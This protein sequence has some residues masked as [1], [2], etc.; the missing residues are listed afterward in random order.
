MYSVTLHD[1]SSLLTTFLPRFRFLLFRCLFYW[2]YTFYFENC[3]IIWCLWM[4]HAPGAFLDT[5]LS[6]LLG[7]FLI[8]DC[9]DDVL[10]DFMTYLFSIRVTMCLHW[11]P[12]R[13][14]KWDCLLTS[15]Y[16]NFLHM[17]GWDLVP[18]PLKSSWFQLQNE[19][20][21]LG[22]S[23]DEVMGPNVPTLNLIFRTKWW[24]VVVWMFFLSLNWDRRRPSSWGLWR[25]LSD[26]CVFI[27]LAFCS[28]W[29]WLWI[30]FSRIHELPRP[31]GWSRTWYR[32]Q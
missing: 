12:I 10:C 7:F 19:S 3:P 13:S 9:F 31:R 4:Y 24:Y 5:T 21:N 20:T 14:G 27:S 18:Q 17:D 16:H 29:R 32:Q 26:W 1:G 25:W 23:M 28:I 2:L 15:I 6:F 11:Y 22:I 30:W 8:F